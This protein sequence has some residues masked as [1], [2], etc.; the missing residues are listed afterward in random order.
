MCGIAGWVAPRGAQPDEGVLRAM[1]EAMAHRGPDDATVKT[2][3]PAGFSFRRLSII[4][5]AGGAQPIADESGRRHVILNGE[6]YNFLEIRRELEEK[7]HRFTTSSDVEVVVHGY[8]VWGDEIVER[9]RGMFALALWDEE[10]KRLLL[11]RDRFGKKPL[12]YFESAGSIVFASEFRALLAHPAVPRQASLEA[13]HHYLTYQYVPAPFT[14]FEGVRKLPPGHLLV[15]EN[16]RSRLRPYWRLRSQPPL[17]LDEEEAA[18]EVRRLLTDAVR[19][20]LMSEV[21][22]GAFLSGGIDSSTVVAL[23]ASF[24][25]V[26]T[27]SIGFEETDYDETPFAREVA[28]RFGT[29]HL[30]FFVKP[31]A[32]EVIPSLVDHYGEPFADSSALPTYYLSRLTAQHVTV[33][34]SGD[35]GDE[36]FA[37]YHRYRY[38]P[39]ADDPEEASAPRPARAILARV[40]EKLGPARARVAARTIGKSVL[41]E[42]GRMMSYF[43]PE[44]KETLYAPELWDRLRANDSYDLLYHRF[45]ETDGDDFLGRVLLVETQTYLPDD[46]LVKVDIAS[47]AHSLEVRAPFL[48]HVLAEF[49]FRLPSRFK[50]KD[51]VGKRLLRRAVGDLLPESILG[52]RKM[53]FGVPLTAWFRGDLLPLLHETLISEPARRRGWFREDTVRGLIDDHAGGRADHSPRLWALLM[54]ETW[55]QRFIDRSPSP[56]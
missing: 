37:G 2:Y 38:L 43:R 56:S 19:M 34:L 45:A 22:L 50:L 5:V 54:L 30:E 10:R 11:A 55:F 25:R 36:L 20:R 39:E 9:L 8:E 16:G 35:G 12:L 31:D 53:G 42:Y 18:R 52:R 4:D 6:I 7:G 49:V 40:I 32:A 26:R 28:E 46:L 33:A 47:M 15:F 1:G 23:M 13:I 17:P 24:G 48:D 29:D 3:G 51:S 21:P 41:E 27:F 44:E 14:A